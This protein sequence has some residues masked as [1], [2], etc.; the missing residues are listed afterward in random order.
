M[1]TPTQQLPVFSKAKPNPV[2]RKNNTPGNV[3][4]S[5]NLHSNAKIQVILQVQNTRTTD[6]TPHYSMK[7]F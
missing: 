2:L 7:M 1:M 4:L 6:R 3:C 5:S